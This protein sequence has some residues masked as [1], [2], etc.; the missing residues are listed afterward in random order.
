MNEPRLLPHTNSVV[1]GLTSRHLAYVIYTSGSTGRPKGVMI[2]HQGVVNHTISRLVDFGINKFGRVLQFSSLNFDLSVIETFAALF[3]GASLHLLPNNIRIDQQKLW[4]Y[5]ESHSI[6]LAVLPPAVLRDCKG[7]PPLSTRLKL[8][9][10]GEELP[11]LQLRMLRELIP[12]GTVINEYGATEVTV[13]AVAWPCSEVFTGDIV[14]VGRPHFN[15][16]VY[17]LDKQG[18]PMPLG[19]VGELYLGGIGVARGYLNQ[20]EL[21]AKAFVSDPFAGDQDARMYK[22]G[23]LARYL[24][25]GNVVFLGRNDHQVKIRGFR[26]EL[27]EIEARLCDHNMV[28]KAA[29]IAI[30]EGNDKR[31]VA[32]V[33]AEPDDELVHSLRT[34]LSSSLPDYMVPSAIVRLDTLPLNS[35]G[36]LDRKA[37][38]APDSA[39]FAR[40]EYEEPQG[41]IETKIAHIWAE[42]LHLD[43]VSRND[44]FFALGGHSLLAVRLMNRIATLGV[45]PSIS[46]L[47]ATPYL[48]SF[49]EYVSQQLDKERSSLSVIKPIARE[50]DLP[51]S[52]SQQRLWFLGQ[53]EGLSQI[54][55]LPLTVRFRGELNRKAWQQALDTLFARHEALRSVFVTVDGQPQ[56]RLL[57]DQSG[58]PI[59][60]E[61]LRGRQDAEV[62]LE[63]LSTDEVNAP[64][65]LA[66]G[67]LIR[68]LMV[69]LDNDEHFFSLT[70]HHIVS[71][72]WSIAIL[73]R[74]LNE[75]Y[76]AYCRNECDPLPPLAIQYPDYA[77]WQRQWLSGDRLE[78]HSSYWRTTLADVPVLLN[79]PTDRPRPP[80]QS[81]AGDRLSIQLDPQL[82]NALKQ[83][84]QK[85]G[86][87]LY[88]T[89]LAAWSSIL[90]RLSGQDDI[91]IGS[92]TANRN[93]PQIESL[94][95]F[96]INTLALRIDLSGDPTVRQ[97]LERV[98]NST[99]DAQTHQD[100]PF[101]QVVDIVQPT[102][103]LSH[104]PLFQVMFVWQNNETSEWQ[105]PAIESID[106]ETSYNIS[107]FDLTLEL[108]E[109]DDEI[110]GS[111]E[112]STALFDRQTMERHIGYLC[113]VLQAMTVDQEQVIS[114]VDVL[115]PIERELLLQ[116]WNSTQ[117]D[118]PIDQCIHHL[119]EQQVERTPQ[120]TALVFMD[121]SLSYSELNARANRLAHHLIGMGVQPDMRVAICVERSFAMI[122]G[123]LAI[124]KAGGAYV[125]LDPAYAS[126]RLRDILTDASPSIVVADESGRKLLGGGAPSYME[127]VDPNT[128]L[129]ADHEPTRYGDETVAL[130]LRDANPQIPA[131]T[132]HHLAYVIYTSG[133]TGKP[134]GVLIEHQG[135]VNLIHG[136]PEI[137]GISSSSRA[138]QF[139]SLSFDHSVSEIFSALSFGAS[140]HLVRDDVRLDKNQLWDYLLRRSITH[141]SLTPA[142]L[143]DIKELPTLSTLAALI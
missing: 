99:L 73:Y 34:H 23:D 68:V 79:L 76:S 136:R 127:I 56:V 66:R 94:I 77:A 26:I 48:S 135:V 100:L 65:D 35:N 58:I 18:R 62:K 88:M 11:A 37:L 38:P 20:P 24:P 126:E 98:R 46:S 128:L 108:G 103:S 67:P 86:M 30:G 138:L 59:R 15:K 113:T 118:Y 25:D 3:S 74:E 123:V 45:Q 110:A 43:R 117:Q 60:W 139:T 41:E 95:G 21:S 52:F 133:S 2:E 49:A 90:S 134:K 112:Y 51:L 69:Q 83:L 109:S 124:L 10:T 22:T 47:F 28:D 122:I 116:T 39:S 81:Y 29:V 101:E 8:V 120:A 70:Q 111:L 5:L 102:R 93:H 129:S 61:D 12:H 78:T 142:L 131:L 13:N 33:V 50:G 55:N 82:T 63:Q 19:A 114:N 91:I 72:G 96:F 32:Y 17:I 31:L 87:T 130:D 105:L 1:G 57:P 141:V 80:Q 115:G 85:H 42:L 64:F 137:S 121:Q 14:P 53:L 4:E 36:K 143:Q 40:Q 107:K 125:P 97:I 106:V 92:P 71:D 104:S 89:I 84:S 75:L 7:F 9:S 16:R 27:G 132:S 6:T 119:F 44:N 140:L 54:Y